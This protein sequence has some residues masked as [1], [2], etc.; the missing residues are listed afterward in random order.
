MNKV[1]KDNEWYRREIGEIL[2]S[3]EDNQK[4]HF[5]WSFIRNYACK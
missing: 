4:L 1:T 3:I 5:L 2:K